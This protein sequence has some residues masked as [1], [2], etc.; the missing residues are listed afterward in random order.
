M[1]SASQP[2]PATRYEDQSAVQSRLKRPRLEIQTTAPAPPSR[3]S[4]RKR[5]SARTPSTQGVV[6]RRRRMGDIQDMGLPPPSCPG[7]AQGSLLRRG[8]HSPESAKPR[9][10]YLAIDPNSPHVPSSFPLVTR[11]TLKELDLE[12]ILRNPQLRHDLLFDPGLQFRPTSGRRKRELYDS[13]WRAVLRELETGC[14]CVSF[15]LEGGPHERVCICNGTPLPPSSPNWLVWIHAQDVVTMRMS[16]RI[17]PLLQELLEVIISVIQPSLHSA[18]PSG[19]DASSSIATHVR[20]HPSQIESLRQVFDL[21]L[22]EQE[23]QHHVFDPSGLFRVIGDLLKCHCAPMRD[24]QVEAMVATAQLCAP[25]GGGSK[26]DAV[27]AIRMCFD[28][29]ELMKLDIA[30][31]QLQALRPFLVHTSA[32]YEL[33]AFHESQG[34]SDMSISKTRRWL[35][36]AHRVLSSSKNTIINHETQT[37]MNYRSLRK[38][39]QIHFAALRALTDLVFVPPV[40]VVLSPGIDTP[41]TPA[42]LSNCQSATSSPGYPETLYL[43]Q[44]RMLV[45]SKD[46]ADLTAFYMLLMLYRQLVHSDSGRSK[47][48]TAKLDDAEMVQIKREIWSIGPHR[49]GYCFSREWH[50]RG[51]PSSSASSSM[52]GE[53]P[54]ADDQDAEWV[55]WHSCMRDVILQIAMRATAARNPLSPPTSPDEGMLRLAERWADSNMKPGSPLSALLRDRVRNAVMDVVISQAHLPS[56]RST[57]TRPSNPSEGVPDSVL[58]GTGLEP[59]AA[60]IQHLGERLAKLA[61]IHLNTYLPLYEQEGFLDLSS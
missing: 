61:V 53:E 12:A 25:G 47:A 4:A 49:I 27:K 34:S 43:D 20:Q 40:P 41:T 48:Q 60:E 28:V 30:N 24:R 54:F 1:W 29:L 23:L 50:K 59:L 11:E 6:G 3:R 5:L 13:Y 26:A 46:T 52:K 14:T 22:I 51:K 42:I 19:L 10:S 33:K 35:Q 37:R 7:P 58:S 38:G 21:D 45:L 57:T 9:L 18:A 55:K 8:P 16:S 39:D 36:D 44:S 15:D 56:Q 2:S 31:H 32:N 17:R